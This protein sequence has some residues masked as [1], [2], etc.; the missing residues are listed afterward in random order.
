MKEAEN[1]VTINNYTE[2]GGSVVTR[3]GESTKH[4]ADKTAKKKK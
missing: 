2:K 3:T 1:N 4:D